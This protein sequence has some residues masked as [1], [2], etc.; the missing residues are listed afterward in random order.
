MRPWP[1]LAD[2]SGEIAARKFDDTRAELLAKRCGLDFRDRAF[3]KIAEL[4]RPECHP[5]QAI[6]LQPEMGEHVSHL[7]VLALADRE[8][9]PHIGALLPFERRL[10]RPVMNAVN[11]DATTQLVEIGL[12]HPTMGA[13]AVAPQPSRLGQFQHPGERAIIGEHQQPLAIDVEAPDAD[14]PGQIAGQRGS[15]SNKVGRP[16][17]SECVLTR[18]TGL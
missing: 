11:G 4:E 9:E 5:D 6:H 18:P 7:A 13:D 8:G 16:C 12:P 3:G 14:E 17:G 15:A 10:D 1:S 2:R